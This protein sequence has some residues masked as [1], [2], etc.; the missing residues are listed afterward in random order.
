MKPWIPLR[1]ASV[2][3]LLYC[4]G[5]SSGFPWMAPDGPEN[6]ALV[7]HLKSFR[8]DL[9]GASRT[10]W[11]FHVGFGLIISVDLLAQAVMLWFIANLAKRTGTAPL[12]PLLATI[13]LACIG[14]AILVGRF[15]FIVPLLMASII[16]FCL[17]LAFIFASR[18]ERRGSTSPVSVT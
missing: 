6:S 5:H 4:A 13:G 11:D 7:D 14:N 3:S 2:V 18:D 1:V 9:M 16:T 8:F 15:F 10:V 17:G 12:R